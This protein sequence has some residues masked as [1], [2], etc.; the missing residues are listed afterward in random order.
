[1]GIY[2]QEEKEVIGGICMN[3]KRRFNLKSKHLIVIMTLVCISLM[4]LA[5]NTAA[6]IEQVRSAAGYL[7]VPFQKGINY[8]GSWL[9]DQTSG[10]T[11]SKKLTKENEELQ[12]KVADLT[13]Q[14]SELLQNQDELKR[15]QEMYDL[16]KAY[17]EYE[18]I[19]AQIISEDPTNWYES[20]VI[21][22]GS[23]DGIAVD[24]NVIGDG[25]LVGIVTAV[26]NDWAT[27]RPLI[28]DSSNVSAQSA[29][30]G[31][32]CIVA[33]DL[34]LTDEGLLQF[35]QLY[36]K[37]DKVQVGDKIV[38]SNVSDKFLKGILIGYISEIEYDSNHLTKSGT[39][40]PVADFRHLQEV[41]VIK[42]LKQTG[43]EE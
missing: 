20:F 19:G 16:D 8:V 4:V 11:D 33:G 41:L 21:N 15:L 23:D 10:F 5:A 26:G 1:M 40:I 22:K 30:T 32:T 35:F 13:E 9:G 39:I 43:G 38:T 2:Y 3:K 37:D 6:P 14:N 18:K 24:M 17:S 25:G 7:I 28:D 27:V 42:Q 12:Q 31:D 29:S 34:T 36:D